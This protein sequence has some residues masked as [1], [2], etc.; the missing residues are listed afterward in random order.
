MRWSAT[1]CKT[2]GGTHTIPIKRRKKDKK[3]FC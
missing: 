3:K 1:F 2:G